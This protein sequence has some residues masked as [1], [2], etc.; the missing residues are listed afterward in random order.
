MRGNWKLLSAASFFLGGGV[1]VASVGLV[2]FGLIVVGIDV[3]GLI[4]VAHVRF[5]KGLAFSQL[6]ICRPLFWPSQPLQKRGNEEQEF[7]I[8]LLIMLYNCTLFY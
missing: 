3:V 5:F 4:V 6:K 1:V 8:S 7:L 2:V